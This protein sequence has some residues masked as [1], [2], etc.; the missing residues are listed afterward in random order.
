MP[1]PPSGTAPPPPPPQVYPN[2]VGDLMTPEEVADR[3]RVS[4]RTIR[5]L[6]ET[7]G[8]PAPIVFSRRMQRYR[9]DEVEAWIT[10]QATA[11][12]KTPRDQE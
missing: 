4:T 10:R 1:P 11:G 7:R 5:T 12:L 2:D 3:L 6:R 8:F 9:R